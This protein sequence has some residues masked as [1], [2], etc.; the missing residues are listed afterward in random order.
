MDERVRKA[1]QFQSRPLTKDE[2]TRL[3]KAIE[4]DSELLNEM[5]EED[6]LD[7]TMVKSTLTNSRKKKGVPIAKSEKLLENIFQKEDKQ[8]ANRLRGFLELNPYLC[9]G[10]GTAFQ[11]KNEDSPGFLPKDKFLEHQSKAQLIREKQEAAKILEMAGIDMDSDTARD[12]LQ[13]AKVREAVIE[14]VQSLATPK[15]PSNSQKKK[16]NISDQ[17]LTPSND[18]D[19]TGHLTNVTDVQAFFPDPTPSLR[20]LR[21]R[22]Q[23]D[24]VCICQRCF[25]LQQYGQGTLTYLPPPPS[26]SL[27]PLFF[28]PI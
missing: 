8:A 25:R 23:D 14:G 9:S 16:I 20:D 17:V 7:G 28:I 4:I 6:E 19:E 24:F 5:A 13:A 21:E 22:Y 12:I 15:K 1:E 3:N 18:I 10:C 27:P 26:C 11:S 2:L